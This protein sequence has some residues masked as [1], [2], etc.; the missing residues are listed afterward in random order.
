MRRFD[1]LTLQMYRHVQGGHHAIP[2]SRACCIDRGH[3]FVT[4]IY[5][6]VGFRVVRIAYKEPEPCQ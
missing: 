5:V 2:Y 3:A 6:R 1:D 4:F